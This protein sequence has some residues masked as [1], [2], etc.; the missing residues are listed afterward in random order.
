MMIF[1]E[2][3]GYVLSEAPVL[4]FIAWFAIRWVQIRRRR[5]RQ[6]GSLANDRR[7]L[8]RPAEY[9]PRDLQFYPRFAL[10]VVAVTVTGVLEL[11]A[12]A[13]FGAGILSGAF[14]LSSVAIVQR[15]LF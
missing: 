5:N 2:K 15:L 7:K 11:A 12:L 1:L 9:G 6:S 14:L 8:R 3:L 13:P 10:A 4:F